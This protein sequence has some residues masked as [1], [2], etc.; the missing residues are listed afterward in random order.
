MNIEDLGTGNPEQ[1][2]AGFESGATSSSPTPAYKAG[3]KLKADIAFLSDD[4]NNTPSIYINRGEVISLLEDDT[5][6]PLCEDWYVADANGLRF[7]L[8]EKELSNFT[9]IK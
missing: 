6:E 7:G 1:K 2:D 4:P 5:D 3:M 9:I 8:L